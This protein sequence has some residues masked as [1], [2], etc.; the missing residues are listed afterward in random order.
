MSNS[1]DVRD[2]T[3]IVQERY[4]LCGQCG[5]YCGAAENLV[6]CTLCGGKL[7]DECPRCNEPILYP[8]GR[9]CPR[10]GMLLV[11]VQNIR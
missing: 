6:Y 3:R 4:R 1:Q 11:Q 10:C 2:R 5:N 7:M 8:T 9:F